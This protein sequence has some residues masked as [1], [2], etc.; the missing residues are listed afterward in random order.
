MAANSGL[1]CRL[2]TAKP[3]N[4]LPSLSNATQYSVFTTALKFLGA[5]GATAVGIVARLTIAGSERA[6]TPAQLAFFAFETA[7]VRLLRRQ[8]NEKVFDQ[9]RD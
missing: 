9:G 2:Q 5:V 3:A 4:Q 6:Y 8:L 7:G 1:K